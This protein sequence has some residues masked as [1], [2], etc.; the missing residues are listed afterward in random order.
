MVKAELG[1]GDKGLAP[2]EARLDA[3]SWVLGLRVYP[4]QVLCRA[5]EPVCASSLRRQPRATR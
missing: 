2:V 1:V 5:V 3:H 4:L